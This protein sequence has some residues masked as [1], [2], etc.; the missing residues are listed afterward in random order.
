MQTDRLKALCPRLYRGIKKSTTTTIASI[1]FFLTSSIYQCRYIQEGKFEIISACDIF[2]SLP[3]NLNICYNLPHCNVMRLTYLPFYPTKYVYHAYYQE[4]FILSCMLHINCIR[5]A[6][7]F[8]TTK[9]GLSMKNTA[10]CCQLYLPTNKCTLY[11][12]G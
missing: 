5:N 3:N 7:N 11:I 6:V 2:S 8:T 10:P 9:C 12:S 1:H 4:N